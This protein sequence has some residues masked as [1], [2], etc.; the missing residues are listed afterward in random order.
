VAFGLAIGFVVAIGACSSSSTPVPIPPAVTPPA[1]TATTPGG[2]A[3][4]SVAAASGAASTTASAACPTEAIVGGALGLTL[5]APVTVPGG[6]GTPL[7]AG[8]TGIA[9]DYRGTASNVIIEEIQNIDPSAIGSFSSKFPVAFAAVAGVG[10]QA[11]SFRQDLNGG[12]DNEGVVATKGSTLVDITAT[13][14]PAT[15]AQLEA[16]VMQLL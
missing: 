15:L 1:A 12:K 14:T 9:C 4:A 16:L 7:P 11:R 13:A 3:A 2:S 8:A 5:S 10:D 6:G